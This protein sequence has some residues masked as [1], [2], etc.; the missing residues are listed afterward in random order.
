M[1]LFSNFL[2]KLEHDLG[3]PSSKSFYEY[4]ASKGP[5]NFNYTYLMKIEDGKQIPSPAIVQ[6]IVCLLPKPLQD[7]LYLSYCSAFFPEREEL[8]LTDQNSGSSLPNGA[9][10]HLPASSGKTFSKKQEGSKV[11]K[12]KQLS[13]AQV[14]TITRTKR[15]YFF[16]ALISQASYPPIIEEVVSKIL[17]NEAREIIEM[18]RKDTGP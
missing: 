9:G 18:I 6:R 17:E 12:S 11:S 1:N 16:F 13:F 5:L 3:F 14:D 2:K 7:S 8:F 4:L 10:T 15:H